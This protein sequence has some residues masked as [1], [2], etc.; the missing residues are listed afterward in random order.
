[1]FFKLHIKKAYHQIEFDLSAEKITTFQSH[2][3]SFRYKR[4]MFG[5]ACAPKMRKKI[6]HQIL[7][8]CVGPQSI[9]GDIILHGKYQ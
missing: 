7:E 6:I 3:G 8:D 1:M 2:K 4:R 9:S 5:T